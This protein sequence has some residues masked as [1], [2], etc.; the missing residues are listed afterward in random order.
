[1]RFLNILDESGFAFGFL[2]VRFASFPQAGGQRSGRPLIGAWARLFII[3]ASAV[4]V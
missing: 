3:L 2:K 4:E 1:M